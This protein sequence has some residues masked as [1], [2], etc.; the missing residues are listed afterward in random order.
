MEQ[1][2]RANMKAGM[3][4]WSGD[5]GEAGEHE[6]WHEREQESRPGGPGHVG[7]HER[8]HEKGMKGEPWSGDLP[9][10]HKLVSSFVMGL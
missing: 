8:E 3:K 9:S 2:K 1:A 10:E 5:T 6:S 7:G 4:G